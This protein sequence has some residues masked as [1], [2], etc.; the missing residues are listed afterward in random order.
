[1]QLIVELSDEHRELADHAAYLRHVVSAP[2][3]D[4][5]PPPAVA[6]TE[7]APAA[8][9]DMAATPAAGTA[10]ADTG[11]PVAVFGGTPAAKDGCLCA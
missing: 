7:P 11:A 5:A 4:P 2:V 9:T 6:T 3:P 8:T 1:M 10:G